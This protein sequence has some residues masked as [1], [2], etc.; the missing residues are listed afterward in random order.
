M[1][2]IGNDGR[3]SSLDLMIMQNDA[4]RQERESYY[5]YEPMKI[6]TRVEIDEMVSELFRRSSKG[7][8]PHKALKEIMH[9]RKVTFDNM[10]ELNQIY[11]ETIVDNL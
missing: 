4:D 9:R 3:L 10:T 6:L 8:D 1:F 2:G 11:L 5:D 7:E